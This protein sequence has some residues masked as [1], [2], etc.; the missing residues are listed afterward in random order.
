ML[1]ATSLSPTADAA[2][3]VAS[4]PVQPITYYGAAATPAPEPAPADLHSD[5]R[6]VSGKIGNDLT[7]ALEGAG[8][9]ERLGREYV[10][11]LARAIPLADGLS[12]EDRFDLVFERGEGGRLVYAGLDRVG[13]ADIALLK[14]TDGN[15]LIWVNA[16]AGATEG[17]GGMGMPVAG[18]VSSRFGNRFHPILGSARFHKG[19][20]LRATSGTPIAAAADGR[21]VAAGWRGGYAQVR[22]ILRRDRAR[23][24]ALHR[25]QRQPRHL[26]Q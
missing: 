3:A 6:R 12:V 1:S 19:V 14:W 5:Y 15:S 23:A 4:P 13:R 2:T 17:P 7:R 10:G 16:D 22:R 21:V 8:V 25:G 20:D 18:S 24:L 9:P 26:P 11:V